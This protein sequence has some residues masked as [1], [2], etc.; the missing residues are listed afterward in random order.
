[1]VVR[2]FGGTLLGVPGLI[3]AYKSAAQE[4]IGA[5]EIIEK[6]I[7]D[8]YSLRFEYLNMNEVMKIVKEENL[9]IS[10]QHFD[11]D[12]SMEISVRKSQLNQVLSK[13]EKIEGLKSEYIF[14]L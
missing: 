4:A 14:S 7:N 1:M 11:N 5:A 9:Q 13:L 3:N 2:Y 12:C 8:V 10:K 6:T